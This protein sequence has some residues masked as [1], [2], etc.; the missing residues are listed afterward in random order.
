MIIQS[1]KLQNIR[2]YVSQKIDFPS[3]SVLLAGDIGSGKSTILLAIEFCLFGTRRLDLSGG[4]LLRH[5]TNEGTVELAFEVS[6]KNVIVKRALKRGKQSI[7]QEAGYIIIN[8]QKKEGTAI[9][10]KAWVLELLGYPADIVSKSKDL[11]FRY[12]VYTPQEQ[13]KQIMFADSE[14][15]LNTLRTVFQFDK[16][17]RI[18]ENSFIVM[19]ELRD[20]SKVCEGHI[21]DLSSKK[22]MVTVKKS[23]IKDIDGK[24]N[25]LKPQVEISKEKV[26]SEKNSILKLEEDITKLNFIEK[27]MSVITS[28]ISQTATQNI[29]LQKDIEQIGKSI[30]DLEIDTKEF[31]DVSNEKLQED[32]IAVEKTVQDIDSEILRLQGSVTG[33][34]VEKKQAETIKNKISELQKCPMCEQNVQEEHK[35]SILTREDAKLTKLLGDIEKLGENQKS[36][37]LDKKNKQSVL[38]ELR[39]K[40]QE[41]SVHQ[42]KL[43]DLGGKRKQILDYKERK[44]NT[45]KNIG[46]LNS[47][48]LSLNDQLKPLLSIKDSYSE[49]KNKIDIA[50]EEERKIA[51]QF[52][53]MEKE[54]EGVMNILELLDKE[55][56]HKQ[57]QETKLKDINRVR[58]WF[59]EYL[60]SLIGTIE[61]HLMKQVLLEFN[62]FFQQWFNVLL[63]DETLSVRLDEKFSPVIQQNGYDTTIDNLSGGEKTSVALA[64]RLALNKVINNVVGVLQTTDLLILDEPT[65]GFSTEQIDKMRDVLD[66]L[67]AKQIILVSHDSKIESF[68]NTVIKIGKQDHISSVIT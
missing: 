12:T 50:I 31:G 1:I 61:R 35:H 33:Y 49:Q 4:T 62:E 60:V 32:I 41:I 14:E 53:S 45:K 8:E 64:Y 39:K 3:G 13:M 18:K 51:L 37:L 38:E 54:K 25:L 67:Q 22:E 57:K 17:K 26:I 66:Q 55:I 52:V 23:E 27:E 58:R 65:D 56:E 59:S 28:Q 21:A 29:S 20:R 24:I 63:E 48:K 44:E 36:F 40:M 5:G 7:S 9:E 19:K 34:E 2:S 46:E 68:V 16:Y 6:G 47:K 30:I 43:K 11:I 42:Y 10:L 15:R